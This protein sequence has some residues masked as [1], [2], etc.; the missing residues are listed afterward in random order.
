MRRP[1]HLMHS[2]ADQLLSP[3]FGEDLTMLTSQTGKRLGP[4]PLRAGE[5]P[6]GLFCLLWGSDVGGR[7]VVRWGQMGGK[8]TV[9]D[10]SLHLMFV[11]LQ[12][13]R[14]LFFCVHEGR[15]I[16]QNQ[17]QGT[18]LIYLNPASQPPKWQGLYWNVN[19]F[20]GVASHAWPWPLTSDSMCPRLSP[21]TF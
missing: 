19:T 20:H 10:V 1:M 16:R 17:D 6:Q 7:C 15:V 3:Q 21:R 8:Y 14:C 11:M 12:A 18:E 5:E 4:R 9:Q 2:Q 13:I